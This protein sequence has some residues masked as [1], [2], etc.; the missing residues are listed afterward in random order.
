MLL[1]RG[2]VFFAPATKL[3]AAARRRRKRQALG[4]TS[5]FPCIRLIWHYYEPL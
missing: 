4:K 2:P 3:G 5:Q 1:L